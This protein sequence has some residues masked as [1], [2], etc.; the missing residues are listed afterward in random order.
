MA[1]PSPSDARFWRLWALLFGA[2][3]LAAFGLRGRAEAG[4]APEATL[5]AFVGADSCASCHKPE[6]EA[7]RGSHHA[8][9][10]QHA[11]SATVLGDFGNATFDHLGVR[12]RFFRDGDKFMVETDGADGKLATF[13]VKF[14]FGVEPLQQYLVAFPDGRMQALPIA[15]DSRPKAS[16]GQRWLHLYGDER[17]DHTDEL[18]WTKLS[19]NWNFMCAG[20]HSTDL[21]KGYD[22]AKDSFHT[23]YSELNVACEACHGPGSRH[24]DWAKAGAATPDDGLA[25]H[26]DERKSVSWIRDPGAVS[27]HRSIPPAAVRKEVETCG[28]CHARAS[29][30]KEDWM[31]G[32]VLSESRLVTP[33]EPGLYSADGQMV[34]REETY[35]YVPFKQSRM[36]AAGVTCS[37]CHDPHS[38]KL[39]LSATETCLSCHAGELAT[40]AHSF[41]TAGEGAPDCVSCHMPK[42]LYMQVDVRHDHSFRIPRPDLSVKLGT[43]NACNDCH[44]DKP[45]AWVAAAVE[46][47]YGPKRKGFQTYAPAFHATWTDSAEAEALLREAAKPDASPPVARASALAA[48]ARYPSPPTLATVRASLADPDPMVRIGALDALENVSG[49]ELT[50]LVAPLLADPAL[51]V[52]VRAVS[53]LAGVPD[54]ALPAADREAWARAVA[55]FEAAQRLNADRPEARATLAGFYVQRGRLDDAE[56]E[57]RASV[58]LNPQFTPAAI[59]LANLYRQRGDNGKALETLKAAVA[60]AP[61][62]G[63][64]H[65]ALGLE[66]V[67]AKRY[68]DALAELRSA[69]TLAPGDARFAYVY[70]V[71]LNS[72]GQSDPANAELDRALK[73]HPDDRDLLSGAIAF[74]RDAGDLQGALAYAER[75]SALTPNDAALA[76]F[77]KDL[78]RRVQP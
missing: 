47:W 45:A 54:S 2:L 36:F 24:V 56:T 53:R 25:V 26:F 32:H 69:T 16:G 70:A 57:Y 40:P 17:L 59:G 49:A 52:R 23:T 51:A 78:R 14:T 9:A 71:A 68:E 67:R 43:P 72:L 11:N 33:I 42:R 8:L 30:L 20:C 73:L 31:P 1:T 34:D 66:L 15:W 48:L 63:A 28:L 74:H 18:H 44:R 3:A 58:R 41:H 4:D 12:S 39:R 60:A 22:A 62:D 46:R 37:D 38:A 13:E 29:E 7:W 35:N 61:G 10:M 65:H 76:A 5:A 50:P 75:L 19:Q 77:V 6:A 21:Q 64:V 27:P 55:D